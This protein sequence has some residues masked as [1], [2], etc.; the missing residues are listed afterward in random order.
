MRAYNPPKLYDTEGTS[1]N[2]SNRATTQISYTMPPPPPPPNPP[3]SITINQPSQIFNANYTMAI[4][5]FGMTMAYPYG[6]IAFDQQMATV[7]Q[8]QHHF[9]Q[10]YA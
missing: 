7:F 5:P 6:S 2:Q 1:F 9:K 10:A 3:A 8:H 4:K